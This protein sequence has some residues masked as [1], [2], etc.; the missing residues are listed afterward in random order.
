MKLKLSTIQEWSWF[1]NEARKR[2]SDHLELYAKDIWITS[3][4]GTPP[5]R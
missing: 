1:W 5:I 2:T 3:P 4:A